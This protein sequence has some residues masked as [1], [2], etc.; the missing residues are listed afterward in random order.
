MLEPRPLR[1]TGTKAGHPRRAP[2]DPVAVPDLR[3]DPGHPGSVQGLEQPRQRS[4]QRG[5]SGSRRGGGYGED[6]K[7][8]GEGGKQTLAARLRTIAPAVIG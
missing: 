1:R 7:S 3:G 4:E 2:P 5:G 6:Q 8:R